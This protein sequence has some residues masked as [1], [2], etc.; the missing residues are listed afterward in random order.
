MD[1]ILKEQG[2]QKT[3]CTDSACA[4]QLGKL[5]SAKK[6]LIGEVSKLGSSIMI[7]VRIVDVEKGVAE[8]AET[9]KAENEDNIDKTCRLLTKKL[10]KNIITGNTTDL[11]IDA[12][13]KNTFEKKYQ[14]YESARKSQGYGCCW[15]LVIPGGQHF[16]AGN[17]GSGALYLIG[18]IT[19]YALVTSYLNKSN[20]YN[21]SESE[22]EKNE[23][24]AGTAATLLVLL[25]VVEV[26]HGYYAVENYNEQ[27]RK[28]L[29]VISNKNE[30]KINFD[31]AYNPKTSDNKFSIGMTLNF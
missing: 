30:T 28:D 6:I 19:S 4:V 8:F 31:F 26:I 11:T 13:K 22:R 17:Y 24:Y 2:F 25:R 14:I 10:T 15:A 9:E 12:D 1:A 27:L 18:A 3:G 16:Y 23:N 20:D 21:L 29:D 7:T 5:L